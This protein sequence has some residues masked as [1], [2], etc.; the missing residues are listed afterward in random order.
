MKTS[1]WFVKAIAFAESC[2]KLVSEF[3]CWNLA[4]LWGKNRH[5]YDKQYFCHDLISFKLMK[6]LI[7]NI[8]MSL[9]QSI[10]SCLVLC[11]FCF[12]LTIKDKISDF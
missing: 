5:P 11:V 9:L 7:G 2:W 1:V 12:F 6:E 3:L 10:Y 8:N 4:V